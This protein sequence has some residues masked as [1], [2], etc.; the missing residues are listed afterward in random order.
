MAS[1]SP[2][3]RTGLAAYREAWA[4]VSRA[5]DG[6]QSWSGHERNNAWL[7]LDGEHFA[8]VSGAT[9][10]DSSE[11]GRIVLPMDWN[12]DGVLDL[13]LRSRSGVGLRLFLG[14]GAWSPAS[15][16]LSL[17][18]RARSTLGHRAEATGARVWVRSKQRTRLFEVRAGEGYLCGQP[19][20]C[21]SPCRRTMRQRPSTCAGPMELVRRGAFPRSS[22]RGAGG[23]APGRRSPG[24][25]RD[26]HSSHGQRR[27]P[28]GRRDPLAGGLAGSPADS[29]TC[30]H[31]RGTAGHL[32][33]P[34]ARRLASA[35]GPA[36][37]RH[38]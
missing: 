38:R 12:G 13:W 31:G 15:G 7:N 6:G 1:R 18:L 4:E 36:G 22:C 37:F 23:L 32:A 27:G 34:S 9:G 11:D 16:H 5:M 26:G 17:D 33:G 29:P 28:R 3:Q 2:A 19:G 20:C 24:R 14:T 25:C 8:D 35:L 30:G 10:L 21:A